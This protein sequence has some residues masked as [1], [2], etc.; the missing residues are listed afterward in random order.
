MATGRLLG[1]DYGLSR[2]GLAVCDELG[3][4]VKPYGH[5]NRESDET[6]VTII[7]SILKQ[8]SI[9]G[10]VLGLP[11]HASGDAGENVEW[12][13]K[14]TKALRSVTDLPIFEVDERYTSSEA[15][16][17]LR[18]QGE[19]PAQPGVLDARA[20]CIILQRHLAGEA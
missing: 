12:V 20:A 13:R 17:F 16:T 18:D 11:L 10:I 9:K 3:I 19:W 2:I 15:E 1:I 14:F 7:A 6:A 4:S 5:V 8:E